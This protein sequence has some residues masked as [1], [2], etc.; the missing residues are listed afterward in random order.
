MVLEVTVVEVVV[1]VVVVV[2]ELQV[3]H[4]AG[5]KNVTIPE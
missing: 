1:V 3:P 2:E 4:I 5:H